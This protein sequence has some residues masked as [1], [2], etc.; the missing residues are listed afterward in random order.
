MVNGSPSKKII[1]PLTK[2]NSDTITSIFGDY[3]HGEMVYT[4]YLDGDTPTFFD[5]DDKLPCTYLFENKFFCPG[6]GLLEFDED[7]LK[8]QNAWQFV[9]K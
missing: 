4:F 9:K 1:K 3:Q 2:L 5:G 6:Y 7:N 8:I